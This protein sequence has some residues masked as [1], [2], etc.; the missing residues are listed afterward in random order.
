V[1]VAVAGMKPVVPEVL[2]EAEV[3]EVVK[4]LVRLGQ[5]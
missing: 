1:V 3:V 5:Q 2:V 4:V